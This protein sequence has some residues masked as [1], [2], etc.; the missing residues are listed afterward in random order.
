MA[1]ESA[2]SYGLGASVGLSLDEA[3]LIEPG[4]DAVLVE[5]SLLSLKTYAKGAPTSLATATVRVGA[6]GATRISPN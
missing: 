3:P 6:E 4:N 5:G 2:L 1:R